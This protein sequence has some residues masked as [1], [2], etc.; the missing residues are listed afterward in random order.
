MSPIA[1]LNDVDDDGA[2]GDDDDNLSEDNEKRVSG[3]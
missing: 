2:D 3:Y 1:R